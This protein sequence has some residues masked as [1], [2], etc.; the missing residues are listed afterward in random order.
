MISN[1]G[2]D[3]AGNALKFLLPN[4]PGSEIREISPPN[5]NWTSEAILHKF[6]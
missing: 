6:S 2:Y 1:C 5:K 4:I 3:F